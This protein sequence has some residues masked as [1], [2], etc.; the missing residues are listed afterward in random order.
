M[1]ATQRYLIAPYNTGLQNDLKPWLIPEDAFEQLQNLYVWR[2]RVKKR[3]GSNL[4]FGT[5]P[6]SVNPQIYSRLRIRVGTTSGAGALGGVVPG[7]VFAVG[8]LFSIGTQLFTVQALGTPVVMLNSTG[9]GSGT[10]NTTTGA[11]SFTGVAINTA[12][13]FYPATP[14]MGFGVLDT[15]TVNFER[16]IAFDTQFAYEYQASG[17]WERLALGA[18]TWTGN[19]SQFFYSSMYRGTNANDLALF[20]TNNN[21]T[22]SSNGDGIR[23]LLGSTSTWTQL[24]QSYSASAN[25]AILGARIVV[26]FKGRLLLFNTWEQ[27][28]SATRVQYQNRV[29]YS[30]IGD[31][32]QVDAWYDATSGVYGKGGALDAPVAQQIISVQIL[33]DRMIVYFERSTWELVYTNNEVLPFRWQNINIELGVESTFSL[34]PFD[35]GLLGVGQ[36]GVH[37][38]NGLNVERIDNKIPDQ[39]FTIQNANNGTE[40]VQGIRDYENE[41]A[42]WACP[43]VDTSNPNLKYPN[44]LL[45]Y[46]YKND[47]WSLWDDSITAFGYINLNNALTWEQLDYFN[48]EEWVTTW[49]SGSNQS[50]MLRV[51]AGNQEGFTFYMSRDFT[52]NASSLQITNIV[53]T[54]SVITVTAINHNLTEQDFVLFENIIGTGDMTSLNGKIYPVVG[55]SNVNT[56]VIIDSSIVTGTYAGGGTLALVSE[57]DLI[58]KQY[59]FYI[60]QGRNF[61][62]DKVDFLV[63]RTEEGKVSVNV[64]PSSSNIATQSLIL[65]T[66]PYDPIYYPLEQAQ[67]LLWHTLYPN[68]SG[69]YIQFEMLWNRDQMIDPEISLDD[70]TLHAMLFYATVTSMR[71]Q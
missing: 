23:Y 66:S 31:P 40:R 1:A 26:Q 41:L 47:S 53:I 8:Q 27:P 50:Q 57:I 39:V 19:D 4:L 7:T 63:G 38:S 49:N 68:T 2:G 55:V 33:R 22:V 54:G 51:I 34:I 6:L 25:T 70:F 45:V 18:S 37:V 43:N 62:I 9:V 67:D 56:F 13:Y 71:L 65:Q 28:G 44:Q 35:R 21:T 3:L 36:V 42:Y 10:Y 69:S 64:Y 59:N 30:Q 5:N 11:Y 46:N 58:T 24:S 14:V 60:D 20:V 52:R 15:T 61:A 48:W 17:G 29:R 32:T 16:Y 12:V